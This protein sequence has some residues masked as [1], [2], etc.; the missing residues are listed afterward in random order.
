MV[1]RGFLELCELHLDFGTIE[2]I[3]ACLVTSFIL[4]SMLFFLILLCVLMYDSENK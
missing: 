2:A 3:I 4:C 1:K